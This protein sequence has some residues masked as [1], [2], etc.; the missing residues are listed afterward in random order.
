MRHYK[1]I[2]QEAELLA[3]SPESVAQF[4]KARATSSREKPVM[5]LVDEDAEQALQSRKHPLIDLSLAQYG[6]HV[7][8]VA[9]LFSSVPAKHP[10]RLAALS[11]KNVEG[12]A[13]FPI[14]L[15]GSEQQLCQWLDT[16]PEEEFAA[17]FENP[18]LSNALLGDLLAR[19]G[20]WSNI[21]DDN[22]R[23]VVHALLKNE[24]M[25]A[26]YQK[27]FY[28]QWKHFNY[29]SVSDAA[30]LLAETVE[31]T[32][33]WA[34]VLG[35]LYEKLET[36]APSVKKPLALVARWRA[37]AKDKAVASL[38]AELN[39][40]GNLSHRQ[41]VRKGLGRLALAQN[42]K[43]LAT[44]L[45]DKDIALRC[46]AYSSGN[47]SVVQLKAA[48]KRDGVLVFDEGVVNPNLWKSDRTRAALRG[49]AEQCDKSEKGGSSAR[50]ERYSRT[51]RE[52]VAA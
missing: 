52:M 23:K 19:R 44:M 26:G 1:T 18:N 51:E 36:A 14:H 5:D 28:D 24:R 32:E 22:L 43:L 49:I 30:W 42:S 40:D 4:L 35:W 46:A 13:S 31:P 47:I 9:A 11:N 20:T 10:T 8:V 34:S 21:S 3:M 48:F 25:H 6:R 27:Q 17:L 45:K 39:A 2:V 37:D 7:T 33:R 38:E 50:R 12:K 29:N 41:R 16:A 15:F